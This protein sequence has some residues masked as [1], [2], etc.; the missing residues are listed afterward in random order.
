MKKIEMNRTAIL[1]A[2]VAYLLVAG[3][4]CGSIH[5]RIFYPKP[6]II[7]WN[8]SLPQEFRTIP[9]QWEGIWTIQ[10]W[11]GGLDAVFIIEDFLGPYPYW[12]S[13]TKAKIIY[14]WGEYAAWEVKSG[15]YQGLVDISYQ[16][17]RIQFSGSNRIFYYENGKLSGTY[18][19]KTK[20]GD[21]QARIFMT[22]F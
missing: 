18:L 4:G 15:Y 22:P 7:P 8:D 6:E 2:M 19:V 20:G 16:E 10:A 21:E 17:G 9:R 3:T 11:S 13:K 14:A 12:W 5:S 1:V